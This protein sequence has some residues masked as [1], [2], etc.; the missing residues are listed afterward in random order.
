MLPVV[1]GLA[2]AGVL[3][4]GG[5]DSLFGLGDPGVGDCVTSTGA[6]DFETVD[7][8]SDDAEAE[9]VGIEEE[10]VSY[11]DLVAGAEVCMDHATADSILWIGEEDP[12]PGTVYCAESL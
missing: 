7:C 9:V 10:E 2:V 8:D 4:F 11:D 1:G 3:A 6:S 5:V 12:E